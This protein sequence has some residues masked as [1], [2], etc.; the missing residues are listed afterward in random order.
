MDVII[1]FKALGNLIFA[2]ILLLAVLMTTLLS[3]LTYLIREFKPLL[4]RKRAN[5]ANHARQFTRLQY[6]SIRK[7][8]SGEVKI[9][10][11]YLHQ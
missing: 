7:S 9:P 2:A 1:F 8:V 5:W 11:D 4:I 6:L 10:A 3:F